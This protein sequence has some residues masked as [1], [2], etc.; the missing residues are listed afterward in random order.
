MLGPD[1][2][3]ARS[4]AAALT[5]RGAKAWALTIGEDPAEWTGRLVDHLRAERA[6][7]GVVW[8]GD[9]GAGELQDPGALL[10]VERRLT[11]GLAGLLTLSRALAE[12][13]KPLE[14]VVVSAGAWAIP[15]RGGAAQRDLGLR[16]HHQ[17]LSGQALGR[18]AARE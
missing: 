4:L 11:S 2:A 6:P 14:L 8:L 1:G 15:G 9:D 7:G 17:E 3:A 12:E 18:R 13:A 10:D 5:A 16:A